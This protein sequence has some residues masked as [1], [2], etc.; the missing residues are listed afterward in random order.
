MT[1]KIREYRVD[2]VSTVFFLIESV[3]LFSLNNYAANIIYVL[4]K[5][6]SKHKSPDYELTSKQN[7]ILL[8][9]KYLYD[10]FMILFL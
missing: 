10:I 1:K 6:N 3:Q 4:D 5:I 8:F 2:Y 7:Y 9:I